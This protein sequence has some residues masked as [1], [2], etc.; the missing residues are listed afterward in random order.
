MTPKVS[1]LIF[2][3]EPLFDGK[4]SKLKEITKISR[5]KVWSDHP[6]LIIIVLPNYNFLYYFGWMS[7]MLGTERKS[8]LKNSLL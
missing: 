1:C 8:N 5:V 2:S 4:S 6:K 7:E 3:V